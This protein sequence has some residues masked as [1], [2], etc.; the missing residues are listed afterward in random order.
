MTTVRI[1][2]V[3][4]RVVASRRVVGT[5][6][7]LR[8][9]SRPVPFPT[10]GLGAAPVG[11]LASRVGLVGASR[12]D[13]VDVWSRR[14]DETT[15]T[16]PRARRGVEGSGTS[17]PVKDRSTSHPE[18][19]FASAA[20]GGDPGRTGRTESWQLSV[21]GRGSFP[22]TSDFVKNESTSYPE[23]PF[24]SDVRTYGRT[25]RTD[26]WSVVGHDSPNVGGIPPVLGTQE[27]RSRRG[28]SSRLV[29]GSRRR[30]E[31]TSSCPYSVPHR[32]R[33][34]P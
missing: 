11:S 2:R 12:R 33:S 6:F 23:D 8:V 17:D 21:E 3:M 34:E 1:K 4:S 31:T 32:F 27:G 26:G 10:E 25:G 7:A 24:A 14:R 5:S 18:D 19:P 9:C 16:D 28:E 20:E 15:L 13:V 30:D 22:G 29:V